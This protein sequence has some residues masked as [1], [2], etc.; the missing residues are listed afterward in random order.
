MSKLI[1]TH[2][3]AAQKTLVEKAADTA[4]VGATLGPWFFK[5]RDA[6]AFPL[7]QKFL[8]TLR[9]DPVHKKIGAVGY[10]WGG[11]FAILLTH[12]DANPA[13]DAAVALHPSSLSL[14]SEV[15]KIARPVAVEVGDSDDIIK[16]PDV[17]KI[18][19][20]FKSKD[21][22]EVRVYEDQVHG[23]SVR[24]DLSIEKDKKAKEKACEEVFLS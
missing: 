13:V 24:S 9:S 19:E 11:R 5:H 21:G 12:T 1:P 17:E 4:T 18:Q 16:M 10:C 22:C 2:E 3:Q 20:I 8:S 14:P 23:F 15:D 6:V 7:I